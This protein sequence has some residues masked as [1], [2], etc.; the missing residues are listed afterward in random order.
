LSGPADG[1]LAEDFKPVSIDLEVGP[2]AELVEQRL[3]AAILELNDRATVGTD[4][5]M[6][7]RIA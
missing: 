6:M 3:D 1:A 5:V 2:A 7:M 4:Q